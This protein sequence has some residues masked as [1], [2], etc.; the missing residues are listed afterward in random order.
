MRAEMV[1]KLAGQE[2]KWKRKYAILEREMDTQIQMYEEQND[3]VEMEHA[4]QV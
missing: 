1:S 2:E 3:Q 4:Q